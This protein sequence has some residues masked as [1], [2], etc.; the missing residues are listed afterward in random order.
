MHKSRSH[1]LEHFSSER[2]YFL[3]VYVYDDINFA[4]GDRK[5]IELT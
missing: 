2:F 3:H 5:E 1:Q 4:H